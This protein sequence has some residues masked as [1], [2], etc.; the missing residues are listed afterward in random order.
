MVEGTDTKITEEEKAILVIDD[1]DDECI[2][3]GQR[4]DGEAKD[5]SGSSEEGDMS[6]GG[7]GDEG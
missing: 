6:M 4:E 7:N 3:C 1:S 5:S 2:G